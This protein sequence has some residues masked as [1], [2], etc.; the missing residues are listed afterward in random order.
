MQLT[1]I[2]QDMFSRVV[3]SELL[4][5][6]S[7]KANKHEVAPHV[8]RLVEWFNRIVSWVASQI[9]LT[10]GLKERRLVLKRF[11]EIAQVC[12]KSL[13]RILFTTVITGSLM[14]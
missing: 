12:L 11:I 5:G 2:E 13:E 8:M 10:A 9:V 4:F 3:P 6:A 1:L 14:V 7:G